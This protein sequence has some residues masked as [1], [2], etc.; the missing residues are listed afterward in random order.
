MAAVHFHR[1]P[2]FEFELQR[3]LGQ[4]A[5]GAAEIGE[6]LATARRIT[7]GDVDSW[8]D[9][10]RD[11]A[12]WLFDISRDAEEAGHPVTAR[13]GYLRAANYYRT[14]EFFLHGNPTDPRIRDTSRRSVRSF[15]RATLLFK[16]PI[17]VVEIPYEDT[18]L[19][20]YFYP[21]E[22]ER[23]T[24]A[25]LVI[26]HNGFD[27]T[28]EEIWAM[29]GRA[30]QERGFSIL[31]F[32]GPGQGQVIRE[33]GIPFRHDW[34]N[35]VTPVVDYALRRPDVDPDRVALIGIS[36]GGVLA[37]RAAAFEKRL[38]AV[39]AWDGVYDA[40]C[41]PLEGVLADLPGSDDDRLARLEADEDEELDAVLRNKST[42]NGT[43]R[44]VIEHG[45]W[46]MGVPHARAL[47]RRFADFHVRQGLAE[48]VEAPTLI[49]EAS[50]DFAFQG[51]PA[52]LKAHLG[53]PATLATFT[54]RRG[55][56]LH[57][58]VDIL[59]RANGVIF[60]WLEE[61]L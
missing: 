3:T 20:G 26:I 61:V 31:A 39:V 32:D 46:V 9:E 45:T 22:G 52:Q 41:I 29:G 50:E 14:A 44:W 36:L 28:A 24:P 34:E 57:N 35:V 1:N 23:S 38:A 18:V 25:P 53:A 40:S 30:G 12:D 60:D 54:P 8:H 59:R 55:G 33:Q 10:W 11:T 47:Y 13:D 15:R 5:Y 37:P 56:E 4:C 51:Q 16:R 6:C 49:L 43:V 21:A 7:E 19:P 17:E 48:Q 58:Q 27:G 2:Q 42:E